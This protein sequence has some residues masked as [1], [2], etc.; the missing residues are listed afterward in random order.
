[1][2]AWILKNQPV[3]QQNIY[4]NSTILFRNWELVMAAYNAGPGRIRSAI[5]RS[6]TQN[7]WEL[8]AYLPAETQSYVPDLLPPVI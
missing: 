3:L 7:Y 1:M 4:I 6:G 8:A 2:S 5:K